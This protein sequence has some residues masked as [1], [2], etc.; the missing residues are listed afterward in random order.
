[1]KEKFIVISLWMAEDHIRQECKKYGSPTIQV[2]RKFT[3]LWYLK[4]AETI[5]QNTIIQDGEFGP[6]KAKGTKDRIFVAIPQKP[7]YDPFNGM[8]RR[9][10]GSVCRPCQN[11]KNSRD[12]LDIDKN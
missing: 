9:K 7:R 10:Y 11:I 2:I 12:R 6:R 1:M 3:S 4:V 8:Q 5:L